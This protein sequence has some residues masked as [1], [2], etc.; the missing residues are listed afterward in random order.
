MTARIPPAPFLLLSEDIQVL[1]TE[2]KRR[3]E[4]ISYLMKLMNIVEIIHGGRD[5]WG[6]HFSH[7]SAPLHYHV[8]GDGVWGSA[9]LNYMK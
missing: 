8:C 3:E 2:A 4:M 7:L 9:N 1:Y 6:G 5:G